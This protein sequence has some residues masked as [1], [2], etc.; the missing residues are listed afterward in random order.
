MLDEEHS[1]GEGRSDTWLK[2][3][4]RSGRETHFGAVAPDEG[5]SAEG[6]S[7]TWPG[8][9]ARSLSETY[10]GAAVP[11]EER[12]AGEA[13]FDMWLRCGARS[14]GAHSCAAPWSEAPGTELASGTCPAMGR[15]IGQRLRM[16]RF[17][18]LTSA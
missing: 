16:S 2:R 3:G 8:R 14:A 18:A 17:D 13:Y 5:R 9:G 4:A 1:A 10:F 6:Y 15:K 7:D 12:S 11:D